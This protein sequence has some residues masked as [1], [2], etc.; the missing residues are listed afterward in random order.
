[1]MLFKTKTLKN[2]SLLL[3]LFLTVLT[4]K[5][6][7]NK[8]DGVAVVV[9]K[10]IV[11]DS[12]I[13]KFKQEVKLRSEGKIT[14][15]D[16]EMLE[17]LM[18]QKLLAHHAV[19]DSITVAQSEVDS[20]VNRS[21]AFFT[22]EY[23]SEKKVVEAYGFNDIEDLKRELAKV[24]RENTLI[25]KEQQK[26]TEKID[27]TPEE[28]RVYFN[29]LKEKNELPEIPA[30]VGLAQLVLYAEATKEE[31]DRVVEKL[32]KIKKEVEA[33]SSF[34]LKAIINSDD[35]SVTRNQGNMG[36]IT[37]ETQF[38]K[39]FK[40][41]AFSLD[42]GQ[43]SEPF[44][45]IFGYHIIQLHKIKGKGRE[46]SHILMQPEISD[47]KLK[48]TKD[49]IE[50]IV[51]EVKEGKITFD[52]AVKKYSED[53]DTKNSGGLLVNPYT[54]EPTFELTRMPP[55]LFARISELKQGDLSDVFYDET[56]GGEKMYK[57]I[58]MKNRTDT[59]KADIVEDYVRMQQF[60]LAKKKEE[61]VTKWSKEKIQETYIKLGN[62]YK[63]C[64]F[65]K[66][67]KKENK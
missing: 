25:E 33:G 37:K 60:A 42:E 4:L 52:E 26:I 51:A 29:G 12:D 43:I 64:T 28:V 3:T 5:A 2:T 40:E 59:H 56:R 7:Q 62:E 1:M 38:I 9:G 66:D 19:I 11:L 48:E 61:T 6:Q 58:F 32:N 45:T 35:P 46:V 16:C 47:E 67:W 20:R 39:E 50:R 21:I 17:E 30:E 65:K 53:D 10:N 24:Q 8:I 57:V 18:Q 34:K 36:V 55:D 31:S 49:E 15:T 14:I 44:K 41:V 63:K 54:Q 27:V 23:G 13:D 22:N